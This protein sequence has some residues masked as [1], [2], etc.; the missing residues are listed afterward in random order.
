VLALDVRPTWRTRWKQLAFRVPPVWLSIVDSRGRT[1]R[2]RIVPATAREGILVDPFVISSDDRIAWFSG[3]ETARIT[4]VR[5]ETDA[6]RSG[7]D[8]YE[9]LARLRLFRADDCVPRAA[10]EIPRVTRF[11]MFGVQPESVVTRFP[12]YPATLDG[13]RVLVVQAP[14]ELAFVVDRGRWRVKARYGI[15]P[16]AWQTNCTDGVNFSV[17]TFVDDKT[18]KVVFKRLLDPVNEPAH[19]EPQTLDLV[20]ELDRMSPIAIRTRPGPNAN[21]DCDLAY[22]TA[23]EIV[24]ADDD[25][26][27]ATPR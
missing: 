11:P 8:A 2:F 10:A 1:G 5:L 25:G 12:W 4:R 19:R 13:T 23:I 22:W 3:G 9:P 24:P 18:D 6:D 27:A 20:V 17:A 14:S 7:D 26:A 15:L 16:R 21:T